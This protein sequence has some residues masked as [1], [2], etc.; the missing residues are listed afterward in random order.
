MENLES[1]LT[2]NQTKVFSTRYV[3]N[4]VS[5][6]MDISLRY[7]DQCGNG[8]NTFSITANIY[9][10]GA[11]FICGG[12]CHDAI[13]KAAPKLVPLIKWHLC[14]ADSPLHYL[15]NTL[16]HVDQ[17][18]ATDCHVYF[19]DKENDTG[20]ECIKYC[21]IAEGKKMVKSRPMFYSLVLDEK[22]VKKADYNAARHS[23]IW[24]EATEEELSSPDLKQKLID[25]LPALMAEFKKTMESL[26]FVY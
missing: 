5:Y 18:E 22:T 10:Q 24:P 4:E 12:C 25:R 19:E 2:K 9:A 21:S 7:D 14:S 11:G 16:Y 8:H 3:E 26:G 17:H 1:V 13:A 15:A 23:A 20:R 6:K